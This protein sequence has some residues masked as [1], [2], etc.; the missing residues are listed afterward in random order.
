MT[1]GE[2]DASAARRD[3]RNKRADG[4]REQNNGQNLR[5]HT[6]PTEQK[7]LTLET[8]KLR[9]GSLKSDHRHSAMVRIR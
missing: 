4:Q 9:A 2:P 5:A 8:R 1:C 7:S 3:D 6:Q